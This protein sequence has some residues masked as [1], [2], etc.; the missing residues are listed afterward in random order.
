MKRRIVMLLTAAAVLS[1]VS[2][3]GSG[4]LSD[5]LSRQ[6]H[7]Q[8][9]EAETE[10]SQAVEETESAPDKISEQE[11]YNAYIDVNND[12]IVGR[13]YDSLD[14]Y[15][16]YVA[17]QEEFAPEDDYYDCYDVSY[18]MDNVEDAYTMAS[19]KSTKDSLD[20][21]F[22]AMYPSLK[23]LADT[24]DQ[25]YDYTDLKSYMDDDYA[26]GKEL[27]ASLWKAYNEYE[28]LSA[29]F[30]EE[31]S[32][33]D[34][35]RNKEALQKLKDEGYESLYAVNCVILSAQAIQE[36]LYNEQVTD[37]NILD[38]DMEKIQPLYDQFVA[39]IETVLEYSKD[40]EKLQNEGIPVNSAYWDTFL[41]SMRNTK[42]SMT[43]VLQ[44][45][46]DQE[47]LSH[48]DTL[49]TEISGNCSLAS[50]YTG[51]SEMIDD[52]NNF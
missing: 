16:S 43:E 18:L 46:K 36:E 21:A 23:E 28:P 12:L 15:F 52:Y 29:V 6:E 24:L 30:M 33:A 37:E 47:P 1:T 11:L 4:G 38:M 14:R 39:D 50:Y 48:S 10:S 41:R 7:T 32:A 13:L 35:E 3:C 49:I 22:L 42:T 51:I 2:G 20:E 44:H 31:L 17:F 40:K 34:K 26:K 25:I 8:E 5:A 19:A 27:H 9:S 45:V